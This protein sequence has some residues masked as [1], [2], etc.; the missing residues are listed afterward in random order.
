MNRSHA[1]E[2]APS[3]PHQSV[4][5]RPAP[6]ALARVRRALGGCVGW[7]AVSGF[8]LEGHAWA[9]P[10]PDVVVNLFASSAQVLGLLT[11][12][13]GKWFF[14]SSRKS[15]ATGRASSTYRIAFFASA[16]LCVL[17]VIGWGLFAAEQN[18]LKN[19]RLQVNINRSG[20]EEGKAVGDVTLKELAFSDQQKRK[21]GVQTT[22]IA[23]AVARQEPLVMVDIRESEEV[24]MGG[25]AGVK[26]VRFPDLM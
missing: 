13:F 5:I 12:I 9:I 20:K 15:A 1:A 23:D 8:V 16:G 18:D 4:Q 22:E 21:D 7:A 10:S 3:D 26:A 6:V 11:V 19:A 17:S 24:E 2:A 14:S 25:I